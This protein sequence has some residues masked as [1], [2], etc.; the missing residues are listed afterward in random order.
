MQ[1]RY[2]I[3]IKSISHSQYVG[4]LPVVL[5]ATCY[6]QYL[7]LRRNYWTEPHDHDSSMWNRYCNNGRG[8]VS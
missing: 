7:I 5:N 6:R 2:K 1:N 4:S 8:N 3:F